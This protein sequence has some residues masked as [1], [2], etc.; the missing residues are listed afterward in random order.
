MKI[1]KRRKK[2]VFLNITLA[3]ALVFILMLI[4]YTLAQIVSIDLFF[5]KQ[6]VTGLKRKYNDI[7]MDTSEMVSFDDSNEFYNY[8]EKLS[9]T[10]KSKHFRISYN[11]VMQYQTA[12][13]HWDK[14]PFMSGSKDDIEIYHVDDKRYLVFGGPINFDNKK[15]EVQIV[16]KYTGIEDVLIGYF[17]TF[18]TISIVGLILSLLAGVIISRQI[19][20]KIKKLSKTMNEVKSSNNLTQRIKIADEKDEFDEL[21]AMFNSMMDE[22][23]N[24]FNKQ[25]QFV[26]D[27]SH[28]LR[29]PLTAL[30]GHLSLIKRWGKNDE[31][32]LDES[33][34]ICL[35]EIDRLTNLVN[36]LLLLSREDNKK[37]DVKDIPAI[38]PDAL[39]HEL[40]KHYTFLN[41]NVKF[42]V[43][44]D[45]TFKIK[46]KRDDLK[47]L[48][49]IFIDNAIKYNDKENPTI[50]IE[51]KEKNNRPFL[52]VYD[53][54]IGIP[55]EE[56]PK[57]LDRFY[58]VEKS[59][60]SSLK[61]FGIGLSIA[62][63][64]IKNYNG[65]IKINSEVGRGTK[66]EIT[67]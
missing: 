25:S 61:S 37:I 64:I 55:K 38:Y 67:F 4:L 42:E 40:I 60:N 58:K 65:E 22:V 30:K 51:L 27:A 11:N 59:R 48:L 24:V 62:K 49:I 52:G 12:F 28:E 5:N 46:I 3:I 57:I 31:Q 10:D 6:Q 33:L 47:Q 18:I 8:F 21:N 1:F 63:T 44:I 35:E 7:I 9:Q 66:I 41:S 26:S 2:S 54:G 36:S 20:L 15:M 14:I 17:P 50:I 43:F 53:D 23:E 19:L 56:L 16:E 45:K 13:K 34:D 32:M 29:T 39:V